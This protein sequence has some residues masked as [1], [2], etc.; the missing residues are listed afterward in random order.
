MRKAI[1]SIAMGCVC[2]AL[3][4]GCAAWT[5]KSKNKESMW[6]SMQF[7]KKPYQKPDKL[8][9]IWTHDILTMTGKPPTRG[10]GGRLY[11]YNPKSQAIPV[12][13][14]LVVHGYEETR[15]G[16]YVQAE[17]TQAD[18]TFMFT[19]EQFTEHFSPSD[20]G[21]SYSIW[22]PWDAADGVQK[23]ITLIPTFKGKDGT[24]LQ[25]EP[26]KLVLPGRKLQ[27]ELGSSAFQAVSFQ[28]SQIPTNSGPLQQ[29]NVPQ[30]TGLRTTTIS[31]P[32]SSRLAREG[33]NSGYNSNV[34]N[35]QV[36]D[37]SIAQNNLNSNMSYANSAHNARA[38]AMYNQLANQANQF[39]QAN[40]QT[41]VQPA[42]MPMQG[43]MYS[44]G[45]FPNTLPNILTLQPQNFAQAHGAQ[46]Y[47]LQNTGMQAPTIQ[48]ATLQNGGLQ[49]PVNQGQQNSTMPGMHTPTMQSPNPSIPAAQPIRGAQPIQPA[50]PIQSHP[51]MSNQVNPGFASHYTALQPGAVQAAFNA[52]P[53]LQSFSPPQQAQ[54]Q[55]FVQPNGQPVNGQ[56]VNGQPVNGQP[57]NGQTV[58]QAAN[59][60]VHPALY[61]QVQ[62]SATNSG[63]VPAQFQR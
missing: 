51:N 4:S 45:Q 8:A 9:A 26:A 36:Q 24:I 35:V 58:N 19:A 28:R 29:L 23:E 32:S 14:E 22:V 50:Q 39:N 18:K 33:T 47:Q 16:L 30:Q 43:G 55:T 17:K 6:S 15:I 42:S 1:M 25:G 54:W 12:D 37:S 48:T 38:Q 49:Y 52:N 21:A 13:G 41:L 53:Q 46:Q 34:S 44:A 56:I 63:Q 62:P 60:A 11:F 59:G 2:V 7:W 10:F 20:M 57:V 27:A 3:T 31:V 61:N 5:D 40:Q